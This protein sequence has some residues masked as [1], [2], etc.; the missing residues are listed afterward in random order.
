MPREQHDDLRVLTV[1]ESAAE[2]GLSL[3]TFKRELRAGRGPAVVQLSKRRVGIRRID[4]ASWLA[5]RVRS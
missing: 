4:F 2:S 5:A 1:K 3:S